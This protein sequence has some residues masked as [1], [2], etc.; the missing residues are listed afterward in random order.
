M[1]FDDASLDD[2]QQAWLSLLNETSYTHANDVVAA[3][4]IEEP[5]LS[6]LEAAEKN[7]EGWYQLGVMYYADD[8]ID[9]AKKAWKKSL[10]LKAN[11]FALRCLANLATTDKD[12]D[13][14]ID[15]YKQANELMTD[16]TL[17]CEYAETALAKKDYELARTITEN[18]PIKSGRL[19]LCNGYAYLGLNDYDK[20][21]AFYDADESFVITDLREGKGGFDLLWRK[22]HEQELMQKYG[23]TELTDDIFHEV[24]KQFPSP[25][26]YNF[27]MA[28]PMSPSER[29]KAG[30]KPK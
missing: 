1:Q 6:K 13:T 10:E 22:M 24:Q 5:W 19:E 9:A 3:P 15:L 27:I 26:K 25:E 12:Y 4:L 17:I 2:D 11:P 20:V 21:R 8:K 18:S 28:P 30:L 29:K 16:I 14:A 23:I 7:H